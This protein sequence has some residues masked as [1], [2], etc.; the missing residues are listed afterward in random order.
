MFDNFSLMRTQKIN[1]LDELLKIYDKDSLLAHKK[2]PGTLGIFYKFNNKTYFKTRIGI[3]FKNIPDMPDEIPNNTAYLSIIS[4]DNDITI[5][6]SLIYDEKIIYTKPLY[7]RISYIDKNKEILNIQ[8][9]T[10]I[11]DIDDINNFII[12]PSESTYKISQQSSNEYDGDWF[13]LNNDKHDV[14]IKS[15]FINNKQ[16]YFRC[17]QLIDGSLKKVC[18]ITIENENVNKKL[19]FIIKNNKRAVATIFGKIEKEKITSPKFIK[20]KKNKPFNSVTSNSNRQFTTLEIITIGKKSKKK[21]I[22]STVDSF[23]TQR[24]IVQ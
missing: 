12:K 13:T 7:E 5:I 8:E 6:D 2:L 10:C 16:K 21:I 19:T 20:L 14:I 11:N 3:N 15:F 18:N 22:S 9:F 23:S 17:F 24:R 4:P 1:N